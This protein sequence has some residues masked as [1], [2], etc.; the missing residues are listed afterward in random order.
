MRSLILTDGTKFD[1]DW[2]GEANGTLSANLPHETDI[3]KVALAFAD[4][5]ATKIITFLYGE[6]SEFHKGFTHLTLVREDGW[7]TG[8]ILVM[9]KKETE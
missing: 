9:L 6:A 1:C 5:E 3:L 8:G 2:C 7:A 4:K